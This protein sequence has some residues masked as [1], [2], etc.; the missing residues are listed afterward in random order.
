MTR[1]LVTLDLPLLK[2]TAPARFRSPISVISAPLRPRV[3]AAIT[4]TL[5]TALSRARRWMKSTSATWSMTGSVSGMTTMLVTPP[6]AAAW[7]AVLSVSRCSSPGSPVNT[8]ISTRPGHS[9]CPLQS[10]TLERSGA[11]RRRCAPKSA[12]TPS[13]T[14]SPP[15]S[16]LPEAGS[17]R[18]ALRKVVASCAAEP[19]LGMA[20]TSVVGQL[21]AHR[22]EHRH[23]HRHAH[24]H[25]VADDAARVIGDGGGDLHAAVHGT[26]MHDE[27]VRLGAGELFMVKA[28]EVEVFAG[29]GHVGA[30][31]ALALQPQH[32]DDVGAF[33]A[34]IHAGED[35][36]A[37]PL[38]RGRQ[39]GGGR[40]DAHPRA[41]GVEH[42][43]VGPGDARMQDVAADR[44]RQASEAALGATDREHIEQSLGR[45]LVRAV[46]G[47]D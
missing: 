25:L 46:A 36:R 5:T 2:A 16:S 18:R 1:A 44:H 38:G 20:R 26:R 14:S 12:I 42:V 40:H 23:A 17:M 34:G 15:G 29:G 41:H 30:L 8:C 27:C 35:L 28:E 39:Q 24:F 4:C 6:A 9:T 10:T 37:E 13:L 33:E 19:F 11:L 7:L 45:M 43:D 21:P 31:H 22:L 3:I 32:H 47:V